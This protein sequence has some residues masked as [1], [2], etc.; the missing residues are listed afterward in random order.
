M[1]GGNNNKSLP[2]IILL[3]APDS[4]AFGLPSCMETALFARVRQAQVFYAPARGSYPL[5]DLPQ[6][7][8]CVL[9]DWRPDNGA[10]DV[11][12]TLLWLEGAK[13]RINRPLN[14][15][16]GHFDFRPTQPTFITCNWQALHVPKGRWTESELLM[17]RS[18]LTIYNFHNRIQSLK[19]IPACP[20]CFSMFVLSNGKNV[21]KF[22]AAGFPTV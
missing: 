2:G 20:C 17:L 3:F 15:Y 9:D 18:R 11:G 13:L 4:Y 6:A 8:I 5:L 16:S 7:Q 22:I 12:C 19:D 10:L 21:A 1:L 14:L